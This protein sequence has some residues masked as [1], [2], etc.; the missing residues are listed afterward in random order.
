M[1]MSRARRGERGFEVA[2]GIGV[3]LWMSRN[4]AV[5]CNGTR[6]HEESVEVIGVDWGMWVYDSAEW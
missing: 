1:V 6:W 4:V 3:G 5:Y 2:R